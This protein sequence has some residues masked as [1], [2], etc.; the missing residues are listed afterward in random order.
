M[1]RYILPVAVVLGVAMPSIPAQAQTID[2]D[3]RCMMVSN[4]FGVREADPQR[5]QVAIIAVAYYLGRVSVRLSPAQ[6]R[7]AILV[8]GQQKLG[9]D[10]PQ[11]MTACAS[12]M[13]AKQIATAKT[14]QALGRAQQVTK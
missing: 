14:I 13:Q 8:I 6:L 1:L 9:K 7:A 12:A 2:P 5:K 10:T 11:V 3:V 4:I